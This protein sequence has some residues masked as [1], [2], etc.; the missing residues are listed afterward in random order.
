MRPGSAAPHEA[1]RSRAGAGSA[2]GPLANDGERHAVVL[3]GHPEQ[4]AVC[5]DHISFVQSVERPADRAAAHDRQHGAPSEV[6]AHVQAQVA[7]QHQITGGSY[8]RD[9]AV[10]GD[11]RGEPAIVADAHVPADVQDVAGDDVLV[12]GAPRF[13][14]CDAGLQY[15][16]GDVDVAGHGAAAAQRSA[17]DVDR[18]GVRADDR[19]LAA[20][21]R[22]R[23]LP[24]VVAGEEQGSA[25]AL[26][27]AAF[28]NACFAGLL[29]PGAHREVEL[30]DLAG[31]GGKAAG[32]AP[33]D[34]G[35]LP[36]GL[37]RGVFLLARP[38]RDVGDVVRPDVA[39]APRVDVEPSKQLAWTLHGLPQADRVPA[40]ARVGNLH[41]LAGGGIRNG[42]ARIVVD[43]GVLP[44]G[45]EHRV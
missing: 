17:A 41:D 37:F 35:R 33:L 13:L 4:V 28:V 42:V 5:P 14:G 11:G 20:A 12:G 1:G 29:A 16:V 26:D 8:A 36:G 7:V 6:P 21:D 45:G 31:V 27:E 10:A 2:A 44:A 9:V 34:L 24:G 39:D 25:A 32:P 23:A 38:D 22:A 18:A 15:S 19:K 3:V 43:G 40:V 30:V